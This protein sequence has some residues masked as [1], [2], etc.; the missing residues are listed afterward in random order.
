MGKRWYHSLGLQSLVKVYENLQRPAPLHARC[1]RRGFF[2][3][4]PAS[5]QTRAA[6]SGEVR[7]AA[8]VSIFVIV[9]EGFTGGGVDEMLSAAR[10]AIH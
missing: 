2:W 6:G 9:G 7:V 3:P 4:R 1:L 10:E 5:P 8:S